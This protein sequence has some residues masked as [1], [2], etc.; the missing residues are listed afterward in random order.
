LDLGAEAEK[1]DGAE[2]WKGGVTSASSSAGKER[3]GLRGRI[4]VRER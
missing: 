4:K 3:V 1:E 2:E